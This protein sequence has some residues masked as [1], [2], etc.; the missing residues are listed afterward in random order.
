MAKYDPSQASKR[1]MLYAI[2]I[3]LIAWAGLWSAVQLPINDLTK[4]LFFALLFVSVASSL[5]PAVAYLNARFGRFYSQRV[6]YARSV[7][8]SVL[9]GGISLGLSSY[10]FS[11]SVA[12]HVGTR[13]GKHEQGPG[14][15]DC[16][17]C[18]GGMVGRRGR[19]A[20]QGPRRT[21]R[22]R[23]RA[24]PKAGCGAFAPSERSERAVPPW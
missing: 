7:R 1:W 19:G 9:V 10:P 8:Q 12:F 5:M 23:R 24:G 2:L 15:M 4:A 11:S 22:R 14:R 16:V 3:A 13:G 6:Y 17:V 18:S 20:A 21:A